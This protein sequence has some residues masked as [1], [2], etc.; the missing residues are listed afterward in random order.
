M[1]RERGTHRGG[2]KV[3]TRQA[4]AQA[5]DINILVN[6]WL[7]TGLAPQTLKKPMYG[8]FSNASDYKTAVDNIKKADDLF[9]SLPA[10]VRA[11]V[12]NDPAKFLSMIFDPDRNDEVKELGLTV[13]PDATLATLNEIK[14]NTAPTPV[15][16]TEPP[17]A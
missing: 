15:A 2:G 14:D 7:Q 1:A 17:A 8:D 12:D 9:F 13:E 3:I 4:D 10:K 16:P 5:A 11:H 6:R